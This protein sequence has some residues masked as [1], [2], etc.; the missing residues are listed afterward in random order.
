MPEGFARIAAVSLPVHLGDVEANEREIMLALERLRTQGVQ[1]AVFPE[2]CLTGYTLGDLLLHGLV[3]DRAW[4][5]LKRLKAHTDG[6]T[7][8]VGLPFCHEGRLYNCAAVLA[9]GE[10]WALV[11]KTY[12]PNGNEFYETRWFASGAGVHE[13]VSRDGL[14][15]PLSADTLFEMG[16]FVFGVELCEDLWV[17]LPPSSHLAVEGADLILN[18]SASNALAAKHAYRRGLLSQQSGRLYAGYAYA[19]A[20]FGESTSDMVFDGYTGVFENGRA[21]SEGER[22][23]MS[24]SL[25]VADVDIGRLRYQR[26][27]NGSFHQMP[28]V[29]KLAAEGIVLEAVLRAQNLKIGVEITVGHLRLYHELNQRVDFLFQRRILEAFQAVGRGL[30]PFSQLAVAVNAPPIRPPGKPRGNAEVFHHRAR[31]RKLR[32]LAPENRQLLPKYTAGGIFHPSIP[33]TARDAGTLNVHR[34]HPFMPV[35][36]MPSTM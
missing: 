29:I 8:V 9:N 5:A 17:P 11:P 19:G 10:I 12:L 27:R 21:L 24:G 2:L 32:S 25:A 15:F 6:L 36:L 7:A 16:G 4:A 22:F 28:H 35:R 30:N 26:Q 14:T 3:Q 33:K 23:S 1:A 20:G 31:M 13:T 18:P 34:P